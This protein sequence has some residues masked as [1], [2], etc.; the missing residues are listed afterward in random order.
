MTRLLRVELRRL[1]ARKVIWLTLAAAVLVALFTVSTVYLQASSIDRARAGANQELQQIQEQ[2]ERDR[3]MCLADEQRER[4]RSGD[5]RVDFGCEQMQAP[6]AEEMYGTMPSLVD[7]YRML[8]T[9]LAYPLMFLGLAMGSTAVAAEFGHRTM[10]SLLTFVP[11]RAPVFASK[12]LAPALA[13]APMA[14]AALALVLVG[15]PAVF[16][17]FRVDDSVTGAQWTSLA[18]M[19]LRVVAITMVA[20]ALGAAAAFLL[21][22]SG[23]VI[24]LLVGYL[25]L[26]ETFLAGLGGALLG[27]FALTR[28]IT[29]WVQHG[30]T[31]ETWPMT[32]GAFEDCQPV[33]HTLSFGAAAT[34]LGVILL[35]VV[36]LGWLWFRRADL[37]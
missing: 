20:A 37:D 21:R 2:V 6:T 17:W 22:H 26:V 31:W 35:V 19:S 3:A 32:C 14:V 24:G 33:R 25:L 12:V 5:P 28:T 34:E 9:G 16:R 7:Q 36:L 23:L 4:A 10:G 29:G 8:L 18:W 13:S 30:T 11:R 1:V 15:V 27:R